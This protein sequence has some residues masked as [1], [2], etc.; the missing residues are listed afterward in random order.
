MA[1]FQKYFQSLV[2]KWGPSG[3]LAR[4][5]AGTIGL[6]LSSAAGYTEL[7]KQLSQPHCKARC[8]VRYMPRLKAESIFSGAHRREVFLRV[9]VFSYYCP[10]NGWLGLI[11]SFDEEDR[12]RRIHVQ[13]NSFDAEDGLELSIE[14]GVLS[15]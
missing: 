10:K 6:D 7:L 4:E 3:G 1:F 14:Q 2:D 9:S 12:L 15:I 13:H 11:L 8:L 5:I